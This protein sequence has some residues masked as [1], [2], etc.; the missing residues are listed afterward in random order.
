M[1][2]M[3]QVVSLP[4]IRNSKTVQTVSGMSRLLAA[5]ASMDEVQLTHA[6]NSS[7][8]AWHKPDAVCTVSELLMMGEETTWNV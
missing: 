6:G 3:F 8:Q 5:T 4:I 2:Y 1:L 7:K